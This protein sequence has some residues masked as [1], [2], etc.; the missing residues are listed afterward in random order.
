MTTLKNSGGGFLAAI[1]TAGQNMA[2]DSSGYL[3][4]M[5]AARDSALDSA[6]NELEE[7]ADKA[8]RERVKAARAPSVVMLKDRQKTSS[9]LAKRLMKLASQGERATS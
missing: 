5:R 8:T 4:R 9:R 1:I 2:G 6:I 3:A 7:A